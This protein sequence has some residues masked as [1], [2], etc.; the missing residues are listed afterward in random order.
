MNQNY[1]NYH[2]PLEDHLTEQA[3]HS[4]D[5]SQSSL[6]AV[7]VIGFVA[8]VI[9]YGLYQNWEREEEIYI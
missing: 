3:A 9:V 8:G 4:K 6:I 2:N 7:F 1:N 5:K